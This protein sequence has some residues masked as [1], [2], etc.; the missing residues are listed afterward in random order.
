MERVLRERDSARFV[1]I[2]MISSSLNPASAREA[3]HVG[4]K[5]TKLER[6]EHE[7]VRAGQER[8]LHRRGYCATDAG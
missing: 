2:A 3:D 7:R 5:P 1:W 6:D 8:T 4:G